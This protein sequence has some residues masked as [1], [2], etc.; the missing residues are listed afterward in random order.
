MFRTTDPE[1]TGGEKT[2]DVEVGE[3]EVPDSTYFCC[4]W[5]TMSETINDRRENDIQKVVDEIF[6]SELIVI[7]DS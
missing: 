1:M 4:L 3:S 7:N 6:R 2:M 5:F